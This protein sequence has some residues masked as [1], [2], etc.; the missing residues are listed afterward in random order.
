M[1]ELLDAKSTIKIKVE[2]REGKLLSVRQ[3]NWLSYR[4]ND[5]RIFI[6]SSIRTLLFTEWQQVEIT[7]SF[8]DSIP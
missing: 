5:A 7:L 6:P 4:F 2:E 8:S 1:Y 3:L